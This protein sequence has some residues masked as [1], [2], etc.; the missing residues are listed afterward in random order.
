[1]TLFAAAFAAGVNNDQTDGHKF[2]L[3]GGFFFYMTRK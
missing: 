3:E 2:T 1:M